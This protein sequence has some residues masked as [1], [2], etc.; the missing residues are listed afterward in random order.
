MTVVHHPD[1]D[2]IAATICDALDDVAVAAGFARGQ[3]NSERDRAS[4]IFCADP[5]TLAPRLRARIDDDTHGPDGP[6]CIDLTVEAR[7]SPQNAWVVTRAD[8][9]GEEVPLSTVALDDAL[10][11]I[12]AWLDVQTGP[13]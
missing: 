11:E 10:G 8:F 3:R 5:A 13:A 12:A 7:R 6:R 9:E 1:A 4:V 2:A